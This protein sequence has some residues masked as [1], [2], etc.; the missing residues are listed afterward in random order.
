[1]NTQY[2]RLENGNLVYA[3]KILT[4]PRGVVM[5]PGRMT[6]LENGWKFLDLQHHSSDFAARS[7]PAGAVDIPADPPEGKEYALSGYNE[8]ATDIQAVYK[9]ID[10]VVPPRTFSKLKIVIALTERGKWDAVRDWLNEFDF[11][12]LFDA[13]TE[14]RED[15][16]DFIAALSARPCVRRGLSLPYGSRRPTSGGYSQSRFGFTSPPASSQ[17]NT[18]CVA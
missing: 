10:I 13:A 17:C 9:L 1:M 12:D 18:R 14:F 16:A 4:T 2:A 7:A 15:N 11:G 3:P 6:Y 5:N 8:T